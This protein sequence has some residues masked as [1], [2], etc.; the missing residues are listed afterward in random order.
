M[1]DETDRTAPRS[2]ASPRRGRREPAT[3]DL[4]AEMVSTERAPGDSPTPPP[5]DEPAA[6]EAA[7][8]GADVIAPASDPVDPVTEPSAEPSASSSPEKPDDDGRRKDAAVAIRTAAFAAAIV[9]AG[10]GAVA[11]AFIALLLTQG[12]TDGLESRVAT[13]EQTVPAAARASDVQGLDRRLTQQAEV[14]R[15]LEQALQQRPPA[16]ADPALADRIARLEQAAG[17]PAA[18]AAETAEAARQLAER[19]GRVEAALARAATGAPAA[20]L[21]LAARTRDGLD[22][23]R[24]LGAEIAALAAL[25]AGEASLAPLKALASGAPTRQALAADFTRIASDRP[26]PA[27]GPD[28]GGGLTDRL[29]TSAANLVRVT[30]EDE[31]GA[32]LQAAARRIEAALGARDIQGALAAWETLPAPARGTSAAWGERMKALAQAHAALDTIANE[33]V[34]ALGAAAR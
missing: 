21:V 20:R 30:R 13:L 9:G 27:S 25:G 23:G 3:I 11:A 14:Q 5:S 28:T 26:A 19:V 1:P 31:A 16:A 4:T 12:T 24:P 22:A 2:P 32:G 34:A 6:G 18:Q 7:A 29:W 10:A 33:A 15:R 8:S 17:A